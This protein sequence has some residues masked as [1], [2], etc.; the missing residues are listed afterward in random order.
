MAW[1]FFGT[2]AIRFAPG[3]VVLQEL[4]DAA[5]ER[6]GLKDIPPIQPDERVSDAR[7]KQIIAAID[8]FCYTKFE[9]F[10]D[11]KT[12]YGKSVLD[13]PSE[14]MGKNYFEFTGTER[15]MPNAKGWLFNA[16]WAAQIQDALDRMRAMHYNQLPEF[17]LGFDYNFVNMRY[18]PVV[19]T[20]TLAEAIEF[21]RTRQD[22]KLG[23]A[24]GSR[25]FVIQRNGSVWRVDAV[26]ECFTF[27]A[28]QPCAFELLIFTTREGKSQSVISWDMDG[29]KDDGKYY[30][31]NRAYSSETGKPHKMI[32]DEMRATFNMEAASYISSELS[33]DF[34]PRIVFRL[35][36]PGGLQK[37]NPFTTG[38]YNE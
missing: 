9:L 10:I 14:F 30:L 18:E 38:E 19:I 15:I 7:A 6:G 36:V 13:S 20:G 21:L 3:G 2:E 11:P 17:N 31:T 1:E 29:I 27:G 5:R 4:Y 26:I 16:E 22:G 37:V 28:V 35:D 32:T 34:M 24:G 33:V 8:D 12:I 25:T 23:V